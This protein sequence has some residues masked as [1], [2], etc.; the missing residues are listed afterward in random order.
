M[1]L[2]KQVHKNVS[3]WIEKCKYCICISHIFT[4]FLVL[5][6][7]S[8]N[9]MNSLLMLV[10]SNVF[11][12]GVGQNIYLHTIEI[13]HFLL[14]HHATDL[15]LF[16]YIIQKITKSIISHIPYYT[17]IHYSCFFPERGKKDKCITPFHYIFFFP[18]HV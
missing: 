14:I 6:F 13:S 9:N 17:Y 18:P 2:L 5:S 4:P 16:I 12:L 15:Y 7:A 3:K 10:H 8:P 11:L 1:L